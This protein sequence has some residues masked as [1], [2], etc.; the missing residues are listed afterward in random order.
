[1]F[2]LSIPQLADLLDATP[3]AGHPPELAVSGVVID[4]RKLQPG[5]AFFALA[6]SQ[7]HGAVFAAAAFAAGAA[8]VVTDQI[9][10]ALEKVLMPRTLLVP[11]STL[12]LQ[13][14]ARWNR[15]QS[16]AVVI[17]ITGSVGKTSTRQL[18]AAVLGTQFDGCQS[19]ANYNNELGVPL[20]LLQLTE[21]HRFA[22][23]EMGAGRAGDIRFLCE[24]AKPSVAIVTR[25]APCHL[26]T[27]GSLEVIAHTKSELPEFLQ[28]ADFAVLNADD[29][30]VVAMTTRIRARIVLIG[31]RAEGIGRLSDV[32]QENE[33]CWFSCGGDE[34]RF[35][36][37]RQLVYAAGAAVI[38]GR[39]WGLS[40]PVIRQGLERFQPE[41]GRGRV[42]RS[43]PWTLIDETY[44][45]SPAS[46]E[47][48]IETL[49]EW[50]ALRRVLVAGEMLE[51]G[52]EAE[53]L[54]QQ[55]AAKL[56]GSGIELVV[57][58]GRYS[59]VAR[60]AAVAAGY[61]AA[62]I[63]VFEHYEAMAGGLPGLLEPGDV[64]LVK[65]SR[66]MRFER[67]IRVLEQRGRQQQQVLQHRAQQ[68]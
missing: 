5:N 48:S 51:L 22:A 64:V 41:A 37:P 52:N 11:N 65:A 27:F 50:K 47:A 60:S 32:R 1:M 59:E 34:F 7:Q 19:P 45:S 66:G 25:V 13:Q 67:L 46:L 38:V 49:G 18:V 26:E 9:P 17:G 3:V 12:A 56:A 55:A 40:A 14:F 35:N 6:G 31:R 15:S 8:C 24:L 39:E 21:H 36:G 62:K 54:H 10:D 44:N 63:I 61:P 4:S 30:L 29:P 23:V 42:I 28:P 2:S 43:G 16:Q 68:Q 57:F 33:G 53:R 20:S 58:T